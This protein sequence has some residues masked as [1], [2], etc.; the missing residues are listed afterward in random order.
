MTTKIPSLMTMLS[1]IIAEPSISST[2]PSYDTSN[3]SVVEKLDSWLTDLGFHCETL[4]VPNSK[5]KYNLIATLG[6]GDGGL[7]LAGHTDTVP[8]NENLWNSDPFTLTE[9]DQKLYGLGTTDMK[10]F[11]P[12]VIEAI[13][14]CVHE[15]LKDL[16]HPIIILATADEETT[17]AGARALV[18]QGRPTARHAIIGEPTGMTPAIMHKGMMME[19]IRIQGHSGHSSD[20][21]LGVNAIE[22]MHSAIGALMAWREHLQSKY[23]NP[24]FA[25]PVPTLNLGC[26]HGGDNPNRICGACELQFDLRPLPGMSIDYLRHEIA[27]KL[28]VIEHQY[29]GI[30]L[31][32]NSIYPGLPPFSGD[33]E[34]EIVKVVETLTGQKAI[35]VAFGTE[36][37]YYQQLGIQPV[38]LGPGNVAQAHQPNEFL[39]LYTLKPMIEI[40]VGAVSQLCLN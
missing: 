26:I 9:V 30:T 37:P 23:N 7:V 35:A 28:K 19:T 24:R 29:P 34:S 10:G 22:A 40:I 31:S 39:E 17:M 4:L 2:S 25:V 13:R 1:E 12:I 5:N 16:K 27:E 8:C 15:G 6:K 32:V 20:P 14:Q 21:S 36:A 18:E 3:Q 11:F 33:E 38:I